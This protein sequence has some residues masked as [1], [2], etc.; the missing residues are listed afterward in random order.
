M[1]TEKISYQAGGA[2][3]LGYLAYEESSEK[4]P[5]VIVVPA[6]EGL[7]DFAKGYAN[8]LAELGYIG[9]AIDVYGDGQAPQ[10]FDDCLAMA[11]SL[12]NN[13][14]L[15]RDRMQDTYAFAKTIE[16]ADANKIAA[17][18]F[19]LGGLCCLDLVRSGAD[20]KGIA[21]FH[22]S[23]AQSD[24]PNEIMT[25]QML[26]MTGM[27]DPQVP[28][29]QVQALCEEMKDCDLQLIQYSQTMH[30]FT[31]PNA[32]DLGSSKHTGSKYNSKTAARSWKACV[33]FLQDL[34]N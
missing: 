29:E 25:A 4:K 11:M 28:K 30:A 33:Q 12:F 27:D 17:I 31:N 18:G 14:Q 34:F 5:L 9:F 20:V 13:R 15:I 32:G 16:Q 24:L 19:C 8:Q 2:T 6:F 10:G 21:S 22:G 3:C 1:I 7:T 26:V 23:L